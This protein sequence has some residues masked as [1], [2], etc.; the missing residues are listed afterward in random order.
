VKYR[1]RAPSAKP[2]VCS[3]VK[4]LVCSSV[5]PLVC[6]LTDHMH[7][8]CTICS[9]QSSP[10]C[11]RRAGFTHS[12]AHSLTLTHTLSLILSH[13]LT[14]SRTHALTHSRT[15][16]LTHSLT[17]SR[18][19]SLTHSLTHSFSLSIWRAQANLDK[20]TERVNR[21][22]LATSSSSSSS[23]LSSLELSDT[24][25][26]CALTASPPR[27]RCTFLCSSCS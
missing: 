26:L 10:C 1:L 25:S 23:L 5:K 6:P 21:K 20:M 11:K 17:R 24:Q 3:S 7:P 12:L 8:G 13:S 27:N 19:R 16:A 9:D 18:T 15:H 4:P 2:L 14:H 22:N